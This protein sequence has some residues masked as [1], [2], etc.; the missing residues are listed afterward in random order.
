MN[1]LSPYFLHYPVTLS[2]STA[3]TDSWQ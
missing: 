2:L 3:P 1:T